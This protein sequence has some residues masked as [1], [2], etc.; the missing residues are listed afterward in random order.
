MEGF[1]IIVILVVVVIVVR[2]RFYFLK[3]CDNIHLNR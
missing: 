3:N 1:L 2:P